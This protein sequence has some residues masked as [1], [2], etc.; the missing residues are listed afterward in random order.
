M[1]KYQQYLELRSQLSSARKEAAT[2]LYEFSS[3]IR[4]FTVK[5]DSILDEMDVVWYNLTSEEQ[6]KIAKEPM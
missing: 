1:T 5:E 2:V 3:K 6:D 4:D